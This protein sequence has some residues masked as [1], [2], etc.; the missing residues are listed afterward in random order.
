M[1]GSSSSATVKLD[2]FGFGNGY[3]FWFCIRQWR[4]PELKLWNLTEYLKMGHIFWFRVPSA[5]LVWSKQ[6]ANLW[7]CDKGEI[8]IITKLQVE[9]PQF[10]HFNLF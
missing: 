5:L 7:N 2:A 4:I 9:S 10:P 3:I 8:R 1:W 6:S